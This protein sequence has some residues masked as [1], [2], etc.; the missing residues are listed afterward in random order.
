MLKTEGVTSICK[1]EF[2]KFKIFQTQKNRTSEKVYKKKRKKISFVSGLKLLM[3]RKC[4]YKL[5]W[6]YSKDI[7]HTLNFFTV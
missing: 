1:S 5:L 3:R 4:I 6:F 2:K 7:L